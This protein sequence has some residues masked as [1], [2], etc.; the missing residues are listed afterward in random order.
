MRVR[1]VTGL[2]LA[3]AIVMIFTSPLRA[4]EIWKGTAQQNNGED[5]SVVI[6]LS[7]NSG[8]TDYPELQCGGTLMRVGKSDNY[9]FYLEKITRNRSRCLDGSITLINTDNAITWVWVGTYNNG[10]PAIAWSRLTRQ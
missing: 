10:R 3:L 7:V 9:S 8:E 1:R 5:Y 6:K 4:Q 2:W